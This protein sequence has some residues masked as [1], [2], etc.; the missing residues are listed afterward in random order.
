MTFADGTLGAEL[1]APATSDSQPWPQ[2]IGDQPVVRA[3]GDFDEDGVLDVLAHSIGVDGVSVHVLFL[4]GQ[5][6][7]ADDQVVHLADN[8]MTLDAVDWNEDGHLDIITV[9]HTEALDGLVVL[10]GDGTG[11]FTESVG[12]ALEQA[13]PGYVLGALDGDGRADDFVFTQG[14]SGMLVRHQGDVQTTSAPSMPAELWFH[15]FVVADLDGDGLGDLAGVATN[16]EF[17]TSELVVFLQK[18]GDFPLT[19]RY[20]VHCGARLLA[21]GDLDSDGA[22]DLVTAGTGPVSVRRGDGQGL[23][24]AHDRLSPAPERGRRAPRRRPRG[25]RQ[26]RHHRPRQRDLLDHRRRQPA[27]AS[28]TC[29]RGHVAYDMPVR[30]CPN[31]HVSQDNFTRAAPAGRCG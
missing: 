17:E 3:S 24:P 1:F 18:S 30:A 15:D 14:G 31:L 22:L 5:G 19:A 20:P 6:G 10:L 26:P 25:R 7:L 9:A 13:T 28:R 12:P 4:D 2:S 23:R 8:V 11:E 27:L 21:A 16:T 29:P